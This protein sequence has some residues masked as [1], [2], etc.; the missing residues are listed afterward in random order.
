MKSIC[1]YCGSK[2]GTNP[3]YREAAID[4]ADYIVDQGLRLINGG[5]NIGI[6]GVMAD[7]VLARGGDCVGVIPLGLREKEVA[8]Y[9]MTE[10]ITVPDMHSRKLCMVN[11]SDAFIA[12]P[13][14]FGTLDELFETLTWS[15]LHLHR[16]P[17]GLLNVNN[18]F[19]HLVG[20]MD[21]MV[22][23]GFLKADARDLMMVADTVSGLFHLLNAPST[24]PEAKWS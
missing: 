10:L 4:L 16:K 11:L 21:H 24:P 7:R 5:G 1:V 9:G 8:H 13:G 18:F 2:G 6:M 15:Q 20:M 14:G 17:I 23:E 3:V 19:D 12:L 22:D